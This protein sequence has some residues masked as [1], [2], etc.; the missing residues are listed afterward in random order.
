[1]FIPGTVEGVAVEWLVDT[2]CSTTIL[3]TKK[4]MEIQPAAR[5]ELSPYVGTLL[6]ADDTPLQVYG[7][8]EVNLH[9]QGKDVRHPVIVA[10]ISNQGLLGLEFLQAGGLAID[11]ATQSITWGGRP[12]ESHSRHIT[13]QANRVMVAEDVVIP[14]GTRT[15]VPGMSTRPLATGD[16]MMEPLE[17]SPG[18]QPLLVGRVLVR[19]RGN[20]VPVEVLNPTEE[21]V[22]LKKYTHVGEAQRLM[23]AKVTSLEGERVRG[24]RPGGTMEEPGR[25]PVVQGTLP[26]ELMALVSKAE[27][28]VDDSERAKLSQLLM[29]NQDVFATQGQPL[30]RT[31]LVQH[32]IQTG[33]AAPIKQHVRR[34]PIHQREAA[35]EEVD[36]MLKQGIIE[37]S[38]SPWASPV[39]LVKKKDG[40]VRYCIDYRQLNAVTR[41]DSY[42]LPRIDDSL[43]SLGSARYFSTLDLASGYWQVGL[44][45]AAKEKSAFCTTSGLYQFKVMPFGLA[46]APATFQRLMERVLMGLQWDMCLVY[47][48]YVIVFS[49]SLEDHQC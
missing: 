15:V 34:P 19:G 45:E 7:R 4:F 23:E 48:D 2:G 29:E 8:A 24:V 5:P 1:M 42:P 9:L 28:A 36:K 37:P 22:S 41:K 26:Q 46:N 31:D 47:L 11:F 32:D 12:V 39:V 20:S 33:E 16:Y 40:S 27:A 25:R 13:E 18:D 35:Q 17:K 6:S 30:G 44:T 10:D 3:S 38:S 49:S 21:D 43:E 14:A